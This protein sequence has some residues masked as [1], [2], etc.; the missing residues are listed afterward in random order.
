MRAK[1]KSFDLSTKDSFSCM[2]FSLFFFTKDKY[3]VVFSSFNLSQ[4]GLL[5]TV[6]YAP[7]CLS[8]NTSSIEIESSDSLSV[9]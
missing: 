1:S 2:V 4:R 3:T 5:L 7:R 9:S 6:V 8:S